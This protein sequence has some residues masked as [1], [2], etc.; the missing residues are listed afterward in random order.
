MNK[1]FM[2]HQKIKGIVI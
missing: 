1:S 2:L